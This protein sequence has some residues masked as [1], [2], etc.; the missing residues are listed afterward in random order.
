MYSIP[1]SQDQMRNALCNPKAKTVYT[2]PFIPCDE[3]FRNVSV[4]MP[5]ISDKYWISSYGRLYD[6]YTGVIIPA[7]YNQKGY[8]C[9][10]I[11]LADGNYLNTSIHVLVCTCFNGP[12]PGP[13][14][15]VNHI[16]FGRHNNYYQNLEWLT[17]VENVKYSVAAGKYYHGNE[18][19]N[20]IYKE[21]QVRQVCELLQVGYS[22]SSEIAKLVFGYS[23][24]STCDFVRSIKLK[25]SWTNI[26][27]EYE[28]DETSY[29][30]NF[31]PEEFLH[32][33]FRFMQNNLSIAYTIPYRDL[34]M[35]IGIDPNTLDRDTRFSYKSIINNVRRNNTSYAAIRS[36]YNVP[37]GL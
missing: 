2:Y 31:A 15:Q 9:V 16:D 23:D 6:A 1:P 34:L 17:L 35:Y 14:Y 8:E 37:S 36:Q 18:H 12:K 24:K 22:K 29:G 13:E 11:R 3:E 27:R 7:R 19:I 21:A 26:S 4:Y 20:A 33:V 30:R 10:N 5:H 28:F 32:K 25:R